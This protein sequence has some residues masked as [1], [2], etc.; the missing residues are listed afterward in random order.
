[1]FSHSKSSISYLTTIHDSKAQSSEE[2][3]ALIHL[4]SNNKMSKQGGPA[5]RRSPQK[6]A[7]MQYDMN[8]LKQGLVGISNQD[9]RVWELITN[10]P[11]L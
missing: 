3:R 11:V 1:M 4:N 9:M 5:G 8:S 6:P 2:C 10:V 7:D